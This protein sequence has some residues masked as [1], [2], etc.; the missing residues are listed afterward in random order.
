M[1]GS[2]QMSGSEV[3]LPEH[4]DA[5]DKV[6]EQ[7]FK[8]VNPNQIAKTLGIKRSKV[9]D[10]IDEWRLYAVNSKAISE[11]AREVVSSA[12]THYSMIIEQSW[13]AAETAKDNGEPRNQISALSLAANT[14]EKRV[15]MLKEAGVLDN[16][17]LAAQ[18]AETEEK[19]EQ[20]MAILKDVTA[21]C[22]QCREEVARRIAK[23]TG[24]GTPITVVEHL[25]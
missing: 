14:E 12:D 3:A 25:G 4:M 18:V 17:E 2:V 8:G 1:S 15:K 7:Y 10:M 13:S 24:K 5:M 20:I 6:M 16:L 11:R 22:N 19:A 21:S 9:L 23:I